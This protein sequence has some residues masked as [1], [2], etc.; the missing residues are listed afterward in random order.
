MPGV[1]GLSGM[2]RTHGL[3]RMPGV[4][5]CYRVPGM[6]GMSRTHGLPRV[7]GV[8]ACYRVSGMSRMPGV[9]RLPGVPCDI[10]CDRGLR[11]S[12]RTMPVARKAV[13]C[14]YAAGVVDLAKLWNGLLLV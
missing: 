13:R 14:G 5:A 12:K 1:P 9:S 8:S 4:S 10:R 6:P 2:S 3:P 11:Y 7:P